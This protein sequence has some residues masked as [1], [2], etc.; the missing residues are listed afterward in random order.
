MQR[1][2]ELS[3][4]GSRHIRTMSKSPFMRQNI[5]MFIGSVSIG[6]LNYLYYPIMGRMLHPGSFGEVQAL[7]S[8]FAQITIF[9]NVLSLLT[10]N[11]V[12]NYA[13]PAKRNRMILELE[14]LAIG[15]SILVLLATIAGATVLQRFFNFGSDLP[16]IMLSA[17]VLVTTPMI[18][19]MG[20]L[21]GKQRFGLVALAGIVAS[22][23]DLLF[24][25][26][27]VAL[28]YGTTG[29]I[30]GLVLAQLIGF[31]V[32][33]YVAKKYGFSESLRRNF[34]RLPDMRLIL[35][36]LKYALLVLIGSLAITGLYSID[37]IVAKHFFDEHTAGL[38][39]GIATI[40]RII[41]FLTA[42][43]AQVLLP[44]VKI[45]AS[46]RE[47]Q[48]ALKKSFL[49]LSGAGGIALV[50]FVAL[51]HLVIT[52]LMGNAY[53]QYAGLLPQLSL[54]VFIISLLN[55]FI[56]YH[57]ALRRYMIAPLV[58]LGVG[59]TS[60]LLTIWHTTPAEIVRS[61]LVG[62]ISLMAL[63]GIW[64]GSKK[65]VGS[66]ELGGLS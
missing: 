45:T 38:Y 58:L 3:I 23:G 12:T 48:Q 30:F 34:I 5:T 55:L 16:F 18:F 21:R 60:W 20:F 54:A 10:V 9:F 8:M 52:V 26:I 65:H 41:F 62:S 27:F 1:I 28:G 57:M 6:A 47:N 61:L 59:I 19:R 39:A 17:A 43:V 64:L 66:R 46:A 29:A 44:S 36:E 2:Q 42:S 13:D 15:V 51:P 25:I 56:M 31:G 22:A 63:L 35:P 7:F 14:K 50:A 53:Q 37:T 33:A 11:I 40:A 32:A 24:S 49:L 4:A